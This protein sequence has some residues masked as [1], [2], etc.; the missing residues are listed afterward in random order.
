MK[1][2]KDN[3]ADRLIHERLMHELNNC[4]TIIWQTCEMAK[5]RDDAAYSLKALSGIELTTKR[6]EGVKAT[7]SD[8]HYGRHQRH[9]SCDVLGKVS[10]VRRGLVHASSVSLAI[11]LELSGEQ[12]WI[13]SDCLLLEKFLVHLFLGFWR[14]GVASV[15]VEF[16]L[17]GEDFGRGEA[18]LKF[19][20]ETTGQPSTECSDSA[21]LKAAQILADQLGFV[22]KEVSEGH[23]TQVSL[24]LPPGKPEES[25]LINASGDFSGEAGTV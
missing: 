4:L 21:D 19:E 8:L 2:E 22:Y 9:E 17:G 14:K 13:K 10:A 16:H 24:K 23:L 6:I 1:N 18:F 11:D 20:G 12:F 7:I 25:G 15:A 3:L 5:I